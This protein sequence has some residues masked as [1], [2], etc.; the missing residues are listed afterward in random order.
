MSTLIMSQVLQEI[1]EIQD[2]KDTEDLQGI[3]DYMVFQENQE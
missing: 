2:H 3:E 1:Q